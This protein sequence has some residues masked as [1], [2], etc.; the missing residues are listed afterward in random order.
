MTKTG[1]AQIGVDKWQTIDGKILKPFTCPAC[2]KLCSAL[3]PRNNKTGECIAC[4]L[5]K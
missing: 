4:T 2:K 3:C 1:R 5:K